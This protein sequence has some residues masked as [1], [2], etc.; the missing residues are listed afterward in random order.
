MNT[1]DVASNDEGT[2]RSLRRLI[3]R[4]RLPVIISFALVVATGVTLAERTS[5]SYRA[6]AQVLI[7]RQD[8]AFAVTNTPQMSYDDQQE[9]IILETQATL[10]N[11]PRVI[12]AT[13][14]AA[15]LPRQTA[16]QFRRHASVAVIAGTDIL[17]F[18][19]FEG[20]PHAAAR[21]VNAWAQA[22]LSYSKALATEPLQ[23]ALASTR[24][25]SGD[26]GLDAAVGGS[27]ASRL[28]AL[29]SLASSNGQV[30]VAATGA[31]GVASPLVTD[32]AIGVVGGLLLALIV[33]IILDAVD[34]RVMDLT[35]VADAT[36]LPVIARLGK[37][38][39]TGLVRLAGG[40]YRRGSNGR[41]Q[42]IRGLRA[43]LSQLLDG[44]AGQSVMIWRTGRGENGSAVP[45]R[46]ALAYAEV[47]ESVFLIDADIRT[48]ESSACLG[49]EAQPGL[50]QSLCGEISVAEAIREVTV[51][52][53]VIGGQAGRLR[54]LP[55]GRT[56]SEAGDLL[57]LVGFEQ[58]L[59]A[60]LERGKGEP[61]ADAEDVVIVDCGAPAEVSSLASTARSADGVVVVVSPGL[62]RKRLEDLV[63]VMKGVS[64]AAIVE[65]PPAGT[66][67][68]R[69]THRKRSA[70]PLASPAPRAGGIGQ[71][72]RTDDRDWRDRRQ[73]Q[74]A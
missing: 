5:P 53:P 50:I 12:A 2:L 58:L 49:V 70:W 46:L 64:S 29:K 28:D 1:T 54:V 24:S 68:R 52:A 21:V 59:D 14:A 38:R 32:L 31:S 10:A 43:R 30:V 51:D 73:A 69:I 13:L 48:G 25:P 3:R 34:P 41:D 35:E 62:R 17:G 37:I 63:R 27:T 44:A 36:G 45:A 33:A 67:W 15:G 61:G 42:G 66:L 55:I 72:A 74:S 4:Y 60:V 20:K 39:P 6:S 22:Y 8:L 23:A 16:S 71:P 57:E 65:A 40:L 7:S 18:S 47:G 56:H 19:D 9:A 26:R 11:T